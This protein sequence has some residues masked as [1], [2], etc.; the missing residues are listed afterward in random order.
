MEP[1]PGACFFLEIFA[2]KAGLTRAVLDNTQWHVLP[3]VEVTLNELVTQP[4]NVFDPGLWMKI[5]NW[6]RAGAVSYL[7]FGTPCTTYS[8]AR[9][10]SNG[11]PGPLRSL[12]HLNGLPGLSPADKAKVDEGN[13]F[14]LM[15]VELIMLNTTL[16]WSIENPASSLMWRAKVH[17]PSDDCCMN[18]SH[19][20]WPHLFLLCVFRD[21]NMFAQGLVIRGPDFNALL[22]PKF[23]ELLYVCA[24]PMKPIHL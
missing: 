11:G 10:G 5:R 4:A 8:K 14:L 12:E 2:G 22:F 18:K 3:P 1:P 20:M 21:M 23:R 15:T 9:N 6:V 7:H 16:K 19:D 13:R 17:F 24:I